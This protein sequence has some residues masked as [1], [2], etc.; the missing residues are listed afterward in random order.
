VWFSLDDGDH[1]QSLRLNMPASSIRDLIIKDDDIVVATHG[2]GFWILDDIEPLRQA[3]AASSDAYL[4]KPAQAWRFRWN[5]NTDTP[6]PPD[7]PAGQNPPD[8]AIIDYYLSG[9]PPPSAAVTL[10]ILD[11][12]GKLVR[13]YSSTDKAD[14][15]KDEGQIPWYWIRPPRVLSTAPGMHRFVWDLHYT[16]APGM[17]RTYPI[18]AIFH[19]TPP[20]PTSPWVM[21]GQY[22]IRLTANGRSTTQPLIVKMDPRV[23]TPP[24]VLQQQLDLSM[25]VYNRV[26]ALGTALE[27]LRGYRPRLKDDLAKRAA[28]LEGAEGSD[29]SKQPESLTRVR[30][31]LSTLLSLLQGSDDAPTTQAAAAVTDRLQASDDVMKRW[32]ALRTEVQK[33]IK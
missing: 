15:P 13:R 2:R 10:E 26:V 17:E 16:P 18:A 6:L 8:G 12:A 22:T 28:E 20:N 23:K 29:T 7:E 25:A 21:P 32:A 24:S 14:P 3:S 4:Y 33:A 30:A 11:S 5:K 1:W 27:E 31:S 19:D 9:T